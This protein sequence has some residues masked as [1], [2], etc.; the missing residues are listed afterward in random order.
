M[1]KQKTIR[2]AGQI[3]VCRLAQILIEHR[4]PFSLNPCRESPGDEYDPMKMYTFEM[5]MPADVAL[6]TYDFAL[7]DRVRHE[8][9]YSPVDNIG[10]TRCLEE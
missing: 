1:E 6:G 4:T 3:E 8:T 9:S 7:A 2:I 10:D 5:T